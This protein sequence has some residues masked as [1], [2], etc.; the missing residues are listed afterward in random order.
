[1]AE[2]F[3][4]KPL[5]ESIIF[6]RRTDKIDNTSDLTKSNPGN[7][8][9][10]KIQALQSLE[11]RIATS[12]GKIATLESIA[13][14]PVDS[15]VI[16]YLIKAGTA[17]QEV[18]ED[19]LF[20]A[21]NVADNNSLK[22]T[23]ADLFK[24]IEVKMAGPPTHV[25]SAHTTLGIDVKDVIP[26]DDGL[27]E[28]TI[29]NTGGAKAYICDG[30]KTASPT[31]QG[32]LPVKAGGTLATDLFVPGAISGVADA[33]TK[34]SVRF[35][36]TTNYNVAARAAA[37]D[38]IDRIVGRGVTLALNE[39][40]ALRDLYGKLYDVGALSELGGFY[41]FRGPRETSFMNLCDISAGFA[42]NSG[43]ITRTSWRNVTF[44]GSTGWIDTRLKFADIAQPLNHAILVYPGDATLQG[45]TRVAGGDGNISLTP[46]RTATTVVGRSR[47]NTVVTPGGFTAGQGLLSIS[48]T[49]P[50][51]VIF[52]QKKTVVV[53]SPLEP[54]ANLSDRTILIGARNGGETGGAAVPADGSFY[55]GPMYCFGV[56]YIT[57]GLQ[58]AISDAMDEFV[59]VTAGF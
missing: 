8:I 58:N 29:V 49:D 37:Q 11:P 46:N 42:D 53:E 13:G 30:N 31:A 4:T 15:S 7:P 1:M 44:D 20:A 19:A 39:E 25:W 5:D 12:E 56:G 27:K 59:A 23:F 6:N 35:R 55:L 14:F 32:V 22:I 10:N 24:Q 18:P 34:L 43:G 36:T 2:D 16:S 52:R 28:F 45:S 51:K 54:E 47:G 57:Q 40:N 50:D 21:A 33:P 48:R 9:G 17:V 41:N 26:L 3:P 38:Y